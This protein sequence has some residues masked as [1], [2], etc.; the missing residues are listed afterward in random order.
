VQGAID[1][2]PSAHYFDGNW[3]GASMRGHS[4]AL[5]KRVRAKSSAPASSTPHKS[6][7]AEDAPR[8]SFGASLPLNAILEREYRNAAA[9]TGADTTILDELT[10]HGFSSDELF[11]LVVP[12]RT[13]ARR[14]LAGQRLSLEETDRAVRLARITAM[15]ERVF[16]DDA[17]AHHWLREPSPMLSESTPLMLLTSETGA[18]VVEEALHRIDYGMFA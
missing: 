5:G 8:E 7:F 16:G 2:V 9:E 12:R 15:A 1:I 4:K 6:G 11:E 14:K 17:K 13:L 10:A 18:Q 3:P